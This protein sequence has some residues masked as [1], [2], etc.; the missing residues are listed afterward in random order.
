MRR[1]F[2]GMNQVAGGFLGDLGVDRFLERPGPT[3]V[4]REDHLCDGQIL[5]WALRAVNS[6]LVKD[7]MNIVCLVRSTS[8]RSTTFV[9]QLATSACLSLL[10]SMALTRRS[11]HRNRNRESCGIPG[12]WSAIRKLALVLTSLVQISSAESAVLRGENF[13][14]SDAVGAEPCGYGDL[15]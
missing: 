6:I 13:S 7:R 14:C 11:T 2:S 3:S 8:Q 15:Q 12:G 1:R 5:R 9:D 10:I 4:A